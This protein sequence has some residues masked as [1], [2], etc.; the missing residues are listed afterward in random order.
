MGDNMEYDILVFGDSIVYGACDSKLGGWVNRLRL[1]LEN[2]RQD[3]YTIFNMGIPGNTT[4][5]VLKRFDKE[6]NLRYCVDDTQVIILA[7]GINDTQIINDENRVT[8]DAFKKNVRKLIKKAKK[9]TDNVIYLG[10][11]KVDEDKVRSLQWT[12][13]KRYN[14]NQVVKYDWILKKICEKTNIKFINLLDVL[15]VTDL[16]DGV[17]P[18]S[19]GYEKIFNEVIKEIK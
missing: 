8:I 17:H 6:M 14:N 10:L 5:D 15:E 16:E 7:V 19:E 2:N 3:D 13:R 9:Y 11:T 1:Y 18:N 4:M 12:H